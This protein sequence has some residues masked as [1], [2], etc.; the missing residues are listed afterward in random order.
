LIHFYKRS[1]LTVQFLLHES[2]SEGLA[3][4][5]LTVTKR[6][7]RQEITSGGDGQWAQS[8]DKESSYFRDLLLLPQPVNRTPD[9]AVLEAC[10]NNTQNTSS[11]SC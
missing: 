3:C 2:V 6:D 8:H 11:S 7:R 10:R 1:N 9:S 4:S 5:C